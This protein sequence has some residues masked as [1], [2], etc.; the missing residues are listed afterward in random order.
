LGR[1]KWATAAAA[2]RGP[3][4]GVLPG[5]RAAALALASRSGR[6]GAASRSWRT[7]RYSVRVSSS[8]PRRRQPPADEEGA[9]AV[10]RRGAAADAGLAVGDQLP[11]RP[12]RGAGPG[13]GGPAAQRLQPGQAP[14]VVLVRRALGVLELPRRAGGVGPLARQAPLAAP[15]VDPAGQEARLEDDDRGAGLGE[16]AA[17]V[18]AV[19]GHGLAA[20]GGGAAALR[21]AGGALV[22]AEVQGEK[23]ARRGRG[24]GRGRGP[25]ASSLGVRGPG[26][27][28]T[29]RLPLPPRLAWILS[30]EDRRWPDYK[31]VAHACQRSATSALKTVD[32]EY[33]FWRGGG[34][35]GPRQPQRRIR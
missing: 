13:D 18:L 7:W 31:T 23:E 17:R 15:V 35:A 24:R 4:P 33:R 30:A 16:P 5:R 25:G 2:A 20:R 3:A 14:G 10:R 8:R 9:A 22:S 12:R 29:P 19:G 26:N 32:Q 6:A 27:V 21:G 1:C 11:P 28:V 34:P